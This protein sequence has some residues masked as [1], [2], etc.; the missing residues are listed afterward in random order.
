[1]RTQ[2]QVVDFFHAAG[3]VGKAAEPLFAGDGAGLRPWVDGW[4]HRLKHEPGAAEALIADLEAQGAALGKKR[5][6]AEVD[7]AL[8]YFRNQVKGRRMDYAELVAQHI[9]IGSRRSQHC[10]SVTPPPQSESWIAR[11][12][13][14]AALWWIGST[15]RTRAPCLFACWSTG[16]R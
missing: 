8:T 15:R 10:Q 6:P 12:A 13:S 14:F 1:M 5:L 9:P 4:C 2:R 11:S 3:Y 16:M 7:S